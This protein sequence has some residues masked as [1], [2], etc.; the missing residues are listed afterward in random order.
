[1]GMKNYR[2][3]ARNGAFV[4]FVMSAIFVTVLT[5]A[6]VLVPRQNPYFGV[7]LV[8]GIPSMLCGILYLALAWRFTKFHRYAPRGKVRVILQ[9]APCQ[10]YHEWVLKDYDSPEE[11]VK[12]AWNDGY[13]FGYAGAPLY[14]FDEEGRTFGRYDGGY[15]NPRYHPDS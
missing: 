8:Y 4:E 7:L 5:L 9:G 11:A 2:A 10:G 13:D 14:L 1:M 15:W 12:R 3:M 6:F